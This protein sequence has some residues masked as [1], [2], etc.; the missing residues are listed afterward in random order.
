MEKILACLYIRFLILL[1]VFFNASFIYSQQKEN[2]DIRVD[3]IISNQYPEIKAYAVIKNSKGELISGL[4]PSLFSFRVDSA[5]VKIKSK[6]IKVFEKWEQK[7]LCKI[8][9]EFS[10]SIRYSLGKNG[11]LFL[12]AFLEEII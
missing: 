12:N 9:K 10:D 1:I 7:K 5:E 2:L 11:I 6:I 3:Q 4:S 8:K